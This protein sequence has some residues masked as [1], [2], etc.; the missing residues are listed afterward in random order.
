MT[1]QT[2]LNQ[3]RFNQMTL[4]RLLA[5]VSQSE[6]MTSPTEGNCI[7]FML[8]H[9]LATRGTAL[10]IT[11]ADPVWLAALTAPYARG[12]NSFPN[13]AVPMTDLNGLVKTSFEEMIAALAAFEPRLSE[14]CTDKMPHLD[15]GTWADRIGSFACHEAY[16]IGQ[17]GLTRRALGKKG[18]F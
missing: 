1:A 7:N 14:P 3:F 16:H 13:G 6:S 2:I 18:L 4:T 15:S 9:L 11:G 12:Q 5:D 10:K 8:G 17:I